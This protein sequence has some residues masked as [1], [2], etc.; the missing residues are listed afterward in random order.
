MVEADL[1]DDIKLHNFLTSDLGAQLPLH[2]SLSRPLSLATADK[3]AFL[4]KVTHAIRNG[5]TG[6]L[7]VHPSELA[8]YHSPESER[9]FLVLGVVA[10]PGDRQDDPKATNAELTALLTR[11]NSVAT[12]F[13]QPA[14]Y[15]GN[16]SEAV[17][18]AFHVSIGWTF[19]LPDEDASLRVPRLLAQARFR[20]VRAWQIEVSGVKA[21]IGNVVSHIPLAADGKR[22][23][24]VRA[25]MVASCGEDVED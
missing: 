6:D 11:C 24:F 8:W 10:T 1:G 5:G 20:G 16:G 12:L 9:T 2:I 25:M 3:D 22:R 14:L 18:S 4:D 23:S 17:G 21:K 13:G 19:G 15:Q 7:V